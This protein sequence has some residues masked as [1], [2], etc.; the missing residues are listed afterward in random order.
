MSFEHVNYTTFYSLTIFGDLDSDEIIDVYYFKNRE[1][2]DEYIDWKRFMSD[3]AFSNE[4]SYL[5]EEQIMMEL[6]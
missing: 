4:N 6:L 5:I 3:L 2:I 1:D